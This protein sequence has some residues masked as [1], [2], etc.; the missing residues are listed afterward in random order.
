MNG[1][2][3]TIQP[4]IF[5]FCGICFIILFVILLSC[6]RKKISKDSIIIAPKPAE[7]VLPQG[8]IIEEVIILPVQHKGKTY[9]VK[10]A[11]VITKEGRFLFTPFSAKDGSLLSKRNEHDAKEQIRSCIRRK[12]WQE[13][14]KDL[15]AAKIITV[16]EERKR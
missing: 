4:E 12:E 6:R 1:W 2:F 16:K 11:F 13:E 5:A 10:C 14:L 8:A 9:R 3:S 7:K 15:I